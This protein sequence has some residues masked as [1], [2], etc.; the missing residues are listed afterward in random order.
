MESDSTSNFG[1][2]AYF[3]MPNHNDSTEVKLAFLKNHPIQPMLLDNDNLPF[4]PNKVYFQTTLTKNT[5]NRKWLSYCSYNKTIFCTTCIC[6]GV[7]HENVSN[8]INGL[9]VENVKSLY[10]TLKTHE[11]SKYHYAAASALLQAK[12]N[13][14]IDSCININV[15]SIH[16]KEVEYRRLVIKRLIDII[17]FIGRQGLPFRGKEEVAYNLQNRSVNHGNFLE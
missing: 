17:V 4:D 14:S 3:I 2:I 6:F 7:N 11:L 13:N 5:I 1:E 8:L 12:S 15:K 9:C 16:M 10:G